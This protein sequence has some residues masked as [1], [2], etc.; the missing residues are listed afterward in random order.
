MEGCS[1]PSAT[2]AACGGDEVPDAAGAVFAGAGTALEAA[3]VTVDT[4][5]GL[6]ALLQA[7]SRRLP[8]SAVRMIGW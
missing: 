3:T 1:R 8:V 7:D 2:S 6:G 5:A 4:G